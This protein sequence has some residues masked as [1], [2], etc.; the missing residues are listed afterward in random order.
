VTVPEDTAF[1]LEMVGPPG[2][3]YAHVYSAAMSARGRAR[4]DVLPIASARMPQVSTTLRLYRKWETPHY[5]SGASHVGRWPRSLL[6]TLYDFVMPVVAVE[7]IALKQNSHA[8]CPCIPRCLL[9]S[10]HGI[11][12]VFVPLLRFRY[13]VDGVRDFYRVVARRVATGVS[14]FLP[15]S[16]HTTHARR[17]SRSVGA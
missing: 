13:E 3:A 8:A 6:L 12:P 17:V 5:R 7:E 16:R 14:R 4:V 15:I 1:F 11:I 10:L 9:P 2:I